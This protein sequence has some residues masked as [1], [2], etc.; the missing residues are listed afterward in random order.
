MDIEEVELALGLRPRKKA[1]IPGRK[2][3]ADDSGFGTQYG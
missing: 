1:C 2:L 3:A